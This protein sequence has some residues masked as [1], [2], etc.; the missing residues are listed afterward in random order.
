MV[1]GFFPSY[2]AP[3]GSSTSTSSHFLSITLAYE[4]RMEKARRKKR[5]SS[6]VMSMF[7]GLEVSILTWEAPRPSGKH[8]G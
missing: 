5:H 3:T 7:G 2:S 6:D 1:F 8:A 4:T